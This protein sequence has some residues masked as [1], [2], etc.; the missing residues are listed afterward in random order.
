MVNVSK[1]IKD[2]LFN[3]LFEQLTR[4]VARSGRNNA[5]LL[6]DGLLTESEKIMLAKRL[7]V[8]LMLREACPTTVISRTLDLSR[9]TVSLMRHDYIRGQYSHVLKLCGRTKEEKE[10]MWKTVDKVLRLGMPSMGKDR[11]E[12]LNR[13]PK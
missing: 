2:E 4:V 12:W 11:W 7:A 13:L 1:R 5:D 6:L 10:Q 3:K 9:S 8:I